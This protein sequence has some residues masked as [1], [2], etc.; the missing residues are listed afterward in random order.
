M[1]AFRQFSTGINKAQYT[2]YFF[3]GSEPESV[4]FDDNLQQYF[5][6]HL[7]LLQILTQAVDQ[8]ANIQ[9]QSQDFDRLLEQAT[10][11]TPSQEMLIPLVAF[12]S[13]FLKYKDHS[14][15]FE[16]TL[17]AIIEAPNQFS[18]YQIASLCLSL[19][20]Q[21]Q[22]FVQG[23]EQMEKFIQVVEQIILAD[24]FVSRL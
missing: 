19:S 9:Q 18:L 6:G 8:Q 11:S 24:D 7:S 21:K 2:Q 4:S 23:L 16:K 12:N 10:Q 17:Q 5:A 1:A 22:Q 14:R 3:S 13:L 15:L 20:Q